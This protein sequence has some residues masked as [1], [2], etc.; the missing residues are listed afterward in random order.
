MAESVGADFAVLSPIKTTASHPA[1]HPLGWARFRGWVDACAMP[2]YALGGVDRA[3]IGTALQNG[4]QGIA[5][6]RALWGK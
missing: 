2:V 5:A 1:A 4:A 3:D 6:L